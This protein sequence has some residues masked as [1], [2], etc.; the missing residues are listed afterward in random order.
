MKVLTGANAKWTGAALPTQSGGLVTINQTDAQAMLHWE[1]FNVGKNTTLYFNQT[2]GKSDASKWVAFNKVFDPSGKP[3]QILGQIKAEGQIYV[4]NQNGIIF[5]S[6]AQVNTRTFVASALPINDNLI[7]R[8]L[9]NQEKGNVEFLFSG[10][11]TGT[12]IPPAPLTANGKIGDIVVERG[13]IIESSVSDAGSGGR[14]MLVGPNVTN[15]GTILTPSGQAILAAGLQVGADAHTTDDPSLRGLDI[16]VGAITSATLG[17]YNAEAS[18]SG[19]IQAARGSVT[20]TGRRVTNSGVIDSS[21]TVDVN[22]R[23]DLIA[24]YNATPNVAYDPTNTAIGAPFLYQST[25]YVNLQDG[26]AVRVLPEWSNTKTIAS[27]ALSLESQVNIQGRTIY[28]GRGSTLLAP[29]GD[30]TAK[31]GEWDYVPSLTAPTSTFVR[32]SGQVYLDADSVIDVS[33]STNVFVALDQSIL[34]VQLRGSELADSPLQRAS[35]LRAVDLTV[36]IRKTGTYNG[37]DWIGT[38]LGDATGFANLI[39]RNV[40]QLTLKGGTVTLS[41]GDSVVMASGSIVDASGGYSRNEG[42]M[43]KTTRVLRGSQVINIADATPDVIYD[44]IYDGMSTS[45]SA[46]WGVSKTY[47]MPLA[48]TGYHYQSEYLAGADA[49]TISITSPAMAL[50]GS[51]SGRTVVG[52][53]QLRSSEI[54][55]TLPGKGTLNLVFEG[56]DKV[57]TNPLYGT[58]SPNPPIIVFEKSPVRPDSPAFSIDSNDLAA[59]IP[60]DRKAKVAISAAL[61]GE[62]GFGNV[63]IRNSDGEALVPQGQTVRVQPGGSLHVT[64]PISMSSAVSLLQAVRF[65]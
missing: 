63:S 9:L 64:V 31:A 41:A 60:E 62:E 56:Q 19:L 44:G 20:M 16:Y 13:A 30:V 26:S 65:N 27:T 50:D 47:S 7:S 46:K 36:D 40:S 10:L 21:T 55:S 25:G 54:A 38:P 29:S 18:N 4:I 15:R 22:G 53:N 49:G 42:G 23:V 14:V 45:G 51:L 48:P 5:G 8:G 52:P 57:S 17:S 3:S 2:Q 32:S 24:S 33:G 12:F 58:I 39:Q 6:G 61:L 37:R 28:F 11:T 34:T 43:V 35:S 1:T 59:Q